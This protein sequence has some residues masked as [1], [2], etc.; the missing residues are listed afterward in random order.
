MSLNTAQD[1]TDMTTETA[2]H[3]STEKSIEISVVE[4][5]EKAEQTKAK[6]ITI[7]AMRNFYI[8]ASAYLLF[9]LTDSALRM[10]VLL[11]LY[12]RHY[13]ALQISIMFMLYEFLGVVTNLVAGIIGARLGLRFCLVTGLIFQLIGIGVLIGLQEDWSRTWVIIYIALA[14]GFSGVAKDMVKL[15]GKSVTKLVTHEDGQHQSKLFKLVAWLTGAK[16]SIKGAGFFLGALLLNIVSYR[17]SLSV[18]LGMIAIIL[19]PSMLWLDSQLAVSKRKEALTL[20]QIFDKGRDVNILSLAR[21][22]LFG[23]RDLWFEVPLPL[24]LRGPFG[25]SFIATGAL[26][27]G[28]VIFYGAVQ[29]STPQLI[30]RPLGIYPIEKATYLVPSTL[31]LLIV[32]IAVAIVLTVIKEINTTLLALLLVG[33]FAFAFVFAINSSIHSFL[34]LSYC[35]RDKVAMNVGFYYMANAMGRLVGLILGGVLFYYVGLYAC[36]WTS[37]GA[38]LICMIVSAF[39]GPLCGADLSP[40]DLSPPDLS[41]PDLSPPDLSPPDLSPP[42]L[43]P[44][45]IP[46]SDH[47]SINH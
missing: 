5:A 25:W 8:I 10:V 42:D 22:F 31:V 38:L 15:G 35:H 2:R 9:T 13:N 33:L 16:N 20:R 46:S 7:V 36:L 27:A 41:P 29:S 26:L 24:F 11:E 40:P 19:P 34:I 1:A 12:Q 6:D 39:L 47:T 17:V 3:I 44:P 14:Q 30:L 23:S 4:D 32:T 45:S 18:L 37:A 43:S 28:W 21:M